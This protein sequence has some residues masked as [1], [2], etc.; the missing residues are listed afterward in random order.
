[1][2]APQGVQ[3]QGGY[4]Y[5]LKKSLYGLKQSGRIWNKLIDEKLRAVGFVPIDEDACVYIRRKGSEVS[6]F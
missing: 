5:R 1:M 2:R 3:L 4:I 6:F